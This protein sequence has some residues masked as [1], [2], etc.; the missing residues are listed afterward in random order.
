MEAIVSRLV[1]A[2]ESGRL[3]RR[4][5]VRKLAATALAA[6]GGVAAGPRLAN[7]KAP[8][9][10]DTFRTLSLDH[11]SFSVS[12][13]GRSR[14]FYS[15]LM[16]WEVVSD[17]GERSAELQMGDVGRIIMRTSR[18][19]FTGTPTAVVDHIAWQI[20][21]WDA[22]AVE[23]ELAARGVENLGRDRGRGPGVPVDPDSEEGRRGYDSFIFRDPDGWAVQVSK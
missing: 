20:A 7:A 16:G 12:D 19:P 13:Y 21:D 17:D 11:I 5:L 3:S 8:A 9:T 22:D 2:F 14:D 1:Q 4:D 10:V 6:G 23:A 18:T 15:D